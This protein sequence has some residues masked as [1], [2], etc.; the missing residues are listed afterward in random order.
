MKCKNVEIDQRND[1]D[2]SLKCTVID[3][4]NSTINLAFVEY[5][6][7]LQHSVKAC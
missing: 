1:E 2:I 7:T 3:N 4:I 5:E 6:H